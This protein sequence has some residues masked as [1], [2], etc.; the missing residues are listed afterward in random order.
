MK[1]EQKPSL[2][3]AVIAILIT[4]VILSP[5]TTF[6][7][8]LEPT[9]APVEKT[10]QTTSYATGDD[11][12]LQKGVAWPDPRFTENEDGTV[13][14]NLTGLIWLQDANCFGPKSW[15]NAIS[16]ANGLADGACGLT[17]GSSAGDWH[18]PNVREL[19]SI[20]HWGFINPAVPNTAGT[21]K[22]SEGDP[23]NDVKPPE[24]YWSSTTSAAHYTGKWSMR[25]HD[26]FII[27]EHKDSLRYVWP[28]R[29]VIYG[30]EELASYPVNTNLALEEPYFGGLD[31]TTPNIESHWRIK[32]T[33]VPF[34]GSG[35]VPYGGHNVWLMGTVGDLDS[36]PP[37]ARAKIIW[38]NTTFDFVS[39]DLRGRSDKQEWLEQVKIIFRDP[40]CTVSPC[41]PNDEVI[42][43]VTLTNE[44]VTLTAEDV[45][46]LENLSSLKA[47]IFEA[48][49]GIPTSGDTGRFAL[50]NFEYRLQ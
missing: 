32:S 29:G 39:M 41:G 6:G 44:W 28:V 25:M 49:A 34:K 50:D 14:D 12:D 22:W 20:T 38:D 16:E 10:G 31:W 33:G 2:M 47:I 26:G 36:S 30:F 37:K 23:F 45:V 3:L 18:L 9:R 5:G 11:G 21:G 8:D 46:G 24:K 43:T 27:S 1:K 7:E 19:L 13:T 15:A 42:K 4:G 40:G 17:D 48:P 35:Y